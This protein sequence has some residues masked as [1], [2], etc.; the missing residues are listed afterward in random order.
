MQ[1]P[2]NQ[3][4]YQDLAE[5]IREHD[6]HY[7][8]EA[9]PVITDYEYDQLMKALIAYEK[10][11]PEQALPDSPA[12]RIAE[13]PTE[14]FK[15]RAHLVPMMSLNNTYS[16]EEL[17]G[18]I[19]RV[20]KLLERQEIEFC[21]ELKMDGASL[22]LC[23]EKGCLAHAVTRG[24]G[25]IGDDVT[26]NIKT[27]SSVPLQLNGSHFPDV[28]EVRAEVYMSLESFRKINQERDEE[29]HE[30]F[31]NPRNAA[32][33]S[34]KMLNPREV[35]ERKLNLVAYGIGEGQSPV[36]TCLLY[37]SPSPRD[38]TRSRMPSSA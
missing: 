38:R 25:K 5:E 30:P 2:K 11:H 14:G 24:N 21:C 19:K 6:R 1:N 12:F 26:R 8:D 36:S 22:S 18:F 29:G 31:A 13:A 20:E 17:G 34:L 28:M 23:Y 35:A 3:Q 33:G 37:T 15:Q 16:E 32:A 10:A 27:I 4:E 7:Y 9:K